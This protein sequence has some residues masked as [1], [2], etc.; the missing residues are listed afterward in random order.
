MIGL[1][2]GGSK[3]Y[4]QDSLMKFVRKKTWQ[5]SRRNRNSSLGRWLFRVS[6]VDSIFK[7]AFD[8]INSET[9]LVVYVHDTYVACCHVR[10]L[11]WTKRGLPRVFLY[12]SY[13]CKLH[14][15]KCKTSVIIRIKFEWEWK[16]IKYNTPE[17][18]LWSWIE[19]PS[20]KRCQRF[21]TQTSKPISANRSTTSMYVSSNVAIGEVAK[22]VFDSREVSGVALRTEVEGA[23]KRFGSRDRLSWSISIKTPLFCWRVDSW[24]LCLLCSSSRVRNRWRSC[25]RD[26]IALLCSNCM[27]EV[28]CRS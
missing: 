16:Q 18:I 13:L 17:L 2:S 1:L 4:D 26:W 23:N 22:W 21:D 9:T 6:D 11:Q 24:S 12:Q 25:W 14:S 20:S 27:Y 7:I 3:K 8:L 15:R 5:N 10:N 28:V 19:F